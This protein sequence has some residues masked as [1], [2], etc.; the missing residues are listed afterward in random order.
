MKAIDVN[1]TAYK[2]SI[3]FKMQYNIGVPGEQYQGEDDLIE[4]IHTSNTLVVIRS[5]DK[6]SVDEQVDDMFT[7]KSHTLW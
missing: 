1:Q 3:S 7:E 6:D 5:A 2:V 4:H